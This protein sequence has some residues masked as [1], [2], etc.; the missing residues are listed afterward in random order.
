MSEKHSDK[1]L[2][3]CAVKPVMEELQFPLDLRKIKQQQ[4]GLV[5]SKEYK[6]CTKKFKNKLGKNTIENQEVITFLDIVYVPQNL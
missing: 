4:I 5:N 1:L 3:C 2:E 6:E